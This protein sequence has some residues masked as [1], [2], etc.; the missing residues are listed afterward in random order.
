MRDIAPG[1]PFAVSETGF[2]AEDLNMDEYGVHIHGTEEWQADYVQKLCAEANKLDALFV[3]WFIYRDY[4]NLYNSMDNPPTAFKI[5][6][7]T[8][9]KGGDGKRRQA[10]NVWDTWKSLPYTSSTQRTFTP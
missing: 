7:D 8:G 6:R 3:L 5:W 4:D 1:K 9:I 2:C 10:H